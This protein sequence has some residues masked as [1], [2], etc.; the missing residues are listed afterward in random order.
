MATILNKFFASV[1]TDEDSL[2]VH[3][4]ENI[5]SQNSISDILISELDVLRTVE[6]IKVN[7]SPGPDKIAPRILKE[8]KHQ[9]SKPLSTLFNKSLTVGKVPSDWKNA[10]VTPIFKKGDKS[11]PGNYRPISLT[12]V[13]GKLMETIL[14][15]NMV[16]FLDD[17]NIINDSQHGFRSK[18]SCLTNLLDFFHYIFYVYDES[19]AVDIVYLDFQKAFDKV[20]HKRLLKKLQTHGISGNIHNW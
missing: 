17:D 10:N 13:V 15:D 14:R 7:K 19:K 12:S 2:S 3:P 20:P 1:F 5:R 4:P 16:K 8:T 11:Q 6:K 18:R 9:I